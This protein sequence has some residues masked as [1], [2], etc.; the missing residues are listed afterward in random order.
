ML[1]APVPE[2]STVRART[3]LAVTVLTLL[4]PLVILALLSPD[5]FAAEDTPLVDALMGLAWYLLLAAFLWAS[6]VRAGNHPLA[7]LSKIPP[8]RELWSYVLLGL[9]LVLVAAAGTYLLYLPLSYVVPGFV[10]AWL[11]DAPPP[12]RL[13]SPL[14]VLILNTATIIAAAPVLEEILFRGF[15]LNRLW[16]KYGLLKGIIFSSVLFGLLHVEVIGGIVFAIVVSLIFVKTGS[17]VG[18]IV[19]HISN[20]TIALIT[21]FFE[22][23]L[24]DDVSLEEFRSLWWIGALGFVTGV[25][26]LLWFCKSRLNDGE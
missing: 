2:L 25:P 21:L 22:E 20:N 10:T 18:P 19:A 26:W 9:P 3:L 14:S 11:L 8:L 24:L 1:Q 12:A 15:L 13:D 5:L 6:W 23:L 16:F 4:L 7:G 17:L